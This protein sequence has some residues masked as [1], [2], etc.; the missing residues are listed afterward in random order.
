MYGTISE[1][2]LKFYSKVLQTKLTADT[3]VKTWFQLSIILFSKK[4]ARSF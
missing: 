1:E 3:V 2:D 4:A